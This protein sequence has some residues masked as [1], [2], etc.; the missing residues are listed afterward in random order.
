MYSEKHPFTSKTSPE[1]FIFG[2][3]LYQLIAVLVGGKLSYEL[4]GIIPSLPIDNI[5]LKHIHQGIPLYIVIIL[6]F[7]QDNA[8]GR[9]LA[10]SLYDKIRARLRKRV[11]IYQREES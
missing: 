4:S 11:F 5:F 7:L 6:V 8:V 3:N 2:L 10:F 9:L 1:K